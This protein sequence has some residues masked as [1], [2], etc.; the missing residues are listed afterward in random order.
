[1][2]R[3]D[4][5]ARHG[6]RD[7]QLAAFDPLRDGNLTLAREQGDT[8][9]LPEIGTD[10][11]LALVGVLAGGVRLR[12]RGH[13]LWSTACFDIYGR[14]CRAFDLNTTGFDFLQ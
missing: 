2:H 8:T 9:H 12:F 4:Q 6:G 5:A 14:V 10:K 3:N 7:A 11:I 13:A 1:M